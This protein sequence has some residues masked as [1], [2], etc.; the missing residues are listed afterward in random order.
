M[1]FDGLLNNVFIYEPDDPRILEVHFK[2]FK[3]IIGIIVCQFPSQVLT[4]CSLPF[5][6]LPGQPRKRSA[7]RSHEEYFRKTHRE[8]RVHG[9]KRAPGPKIKVRINCK[10]LRGESQGS[11]V[12]NSGPG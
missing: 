1:E 11:Q 6:T 10:M 2:L 3:D 9:P 8:R 12:I 5:M 4:P 7:F